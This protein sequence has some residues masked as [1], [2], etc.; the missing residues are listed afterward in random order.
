[1]YSIELLNALKVY[2]IN[3][4]VIRFIQCTEITLINFRQTVVLK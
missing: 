4:C 3:T 1:M 2:P